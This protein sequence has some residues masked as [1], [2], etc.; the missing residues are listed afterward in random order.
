MMDR[1]KLLQGCATPGAHHMRCNQL[2][3]SLCGCECHVTGVAR[4][5]RLCV[6]LLDWLCWLPQCPDG[7]KI[8]QLWSTMLA[9]QPEVH[10]RCANSTTR[11]S[12]DGRSLQTPWVTAIADHT[13]VFLTLQLPYRLCAPGTAAPKHPPSQGRGKTPSSW[14][15]CTLSH[16]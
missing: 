4:H 3:D 16:R 5:V 11:K 1:S 10:R 2:C 6:H 8:I 14:Q 13:F 15:P 9:A 7:V 12:R